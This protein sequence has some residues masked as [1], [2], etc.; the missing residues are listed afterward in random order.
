MSTPSLTTEV[1]AHL[2][3]EV[4]SLQSVSGALEMADLMQRSTLPQ[5]LPA[6][7][8]L[9]E[10]LVGTP[11]GLLGDFHHQEL[12]ETVGVI[13][14][15]RKSN[16]PHGAGLSD[17]LTE[18]RETIRLTLSGWTPDAARVAPLN[19]G[20]A[21]LTGYGGGAGFLHMTFTTDWE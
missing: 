21:K 13:V 20:T 1:M 5:R 15:A 19:F 17:R 14:V 2:R 8:V 12:R 16:D 6:A 9:S 3:R 4:P 18:L 7:F 10:E 11:D